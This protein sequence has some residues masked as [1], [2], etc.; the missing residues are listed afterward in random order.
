MEGIIGRGERRHFAV[1]EQSVLQM[2]ALFP[3][4]RAIRDQL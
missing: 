4:P 2:N 3:Q 1:R